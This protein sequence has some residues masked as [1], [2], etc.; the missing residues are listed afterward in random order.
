MNVYMTILNVTII[1][2][3][4]KKHST[5]MKYTK[6]YYLNLFSISEGQVWGDP[7]RYKLLGPNLLICNFIN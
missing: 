5:N 4:H 2:N 7:R 3:F 1:Q 6:I